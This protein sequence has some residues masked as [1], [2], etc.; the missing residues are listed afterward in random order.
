[1]LLAAGLSLFTLPARESLASSPWWWHHENKCASPECSSPDGALSPDAIQGT[2]SWLRTP[3]EQKRV[4]MSLYNRYCIRCH[5][6]DGRG[7]WDIPNVPDFTNPNWQVCRT[8]PEIVRAIIEG[9]NWC[10]PPFRLALTTA[11]A[12]SMAHYLRTFVPGTEVSRPDVTSNP[13]RQAP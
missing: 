8:D 12:L 6:V 13:P 7:V 11:E 5:G 2:W 1:M 9:K 3:E 10:M 4:T